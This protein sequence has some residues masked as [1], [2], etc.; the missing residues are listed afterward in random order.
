MPGVNSTAVFSWNRISCSSILA[1]FGDAEQCTEMHRYAAE[2]VGRT[3]QQILCICVCLSAW[4]IAH[5]SS[6][7]LHTVYL[8]HSLIVNQLWHGPVACCSVRLWC[9]LSVRQFNYHLCN[10][11]M[12]LRRVWISSYSGEHEDVQ[13]TSDGVYITRCHHARKLLVNFNFYC[14]SRLLFDNVYHCGSFSV[15]YRFCFSS[16]R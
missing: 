2:S 8:D 15:A 5:L 7:V 3:A 12:F 16:F 13:F 1:V 6:S 14:F 4:H 10:C 9:W 11:I